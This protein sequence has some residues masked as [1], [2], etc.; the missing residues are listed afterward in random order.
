MLTISLGADLHF[1]DAVDRGSG[2]QK[3]GDGVEVPVLTGYGEWCP[4]VVVLSLQVSTSLDEDARS[5]AEATQ[6]S[7]VK[8]CV[9]VDVGVVDQ[10]LVLLHNLA[11]DTAVPRQR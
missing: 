5:L 10:P 1:I 7:G 8:R 2:A 6:G 9:P 3:L 4:L 11:D